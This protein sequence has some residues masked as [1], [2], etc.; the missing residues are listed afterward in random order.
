MR[1]MLSEG[2]VGVMGEAEGGVRSTST[3]KYCIPLNVP[4]RNV[5]VHSV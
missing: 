5:S 3:K 4:L 2:S 1:L